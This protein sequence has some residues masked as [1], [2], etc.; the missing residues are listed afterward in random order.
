MGSGSGGGGTTE[1]Y[2]KQSPEVAA[3]QR[4]AIPHLRE[5]MSQNPLEQYAANQPRQIAGTNPAY[6][7]AMGPMTS[8]MSRQGMPQQFI[9]GANPTGTV[10]Q[11]LTAEDVAMV[12]PSGLP[13]GVTTPDPYP[14]TSP[15]SVDD[16]VKAQIEKSMQGFYGGPIGNIDFFKFLQGHWE[17][18]PYVPDSYDNIHDRAVPGYQPVDVWVPGPGT[19]PPTY[20]S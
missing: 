12:N 17:A 3:V 19:P 5:M 13:T 16:M 18:Q 1:S 20:I 10:F 8:A 7:I 4:M 2:E 9:W 14:G 15:Q 6:E 11:G